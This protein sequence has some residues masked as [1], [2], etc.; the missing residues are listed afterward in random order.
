MVDSIPLVAD[1]DGTLYKGDITI[2][3]AFLLLKR[4]P[5]LFFKFL[6]LLLRG[7]APFKRA[8]ASNVEIEVEDLPWN[9]EFL[10]YLKAQAKLGRELLLVSASDELLVRPVGEHLGI[11][12]ESIGSDGEVNLK[13]QTKREYLVKRFGEKGFD[14]AGNDKADY[15]VW[16]SAKNAIVVNAR[17][18]VESKAKKSVNVSH[19]FPPE[20]EKWRSILKS[21]RVHQ[22]LKNLL[23][24]LPLVLAH[25]TSDLVLI[26]QAFLAFLAFCLCASA[27]YTINDAV[28]LEADRAHKNKRRRPLPAGDISLVDAISLAFVLLF[29][30]AILCTALPFLFTEC[31]ILYLAVCLLYSFVLKRIEI[32]D[33][34]VLAQLY[35]LRIMAGGVAVGVKVSHWLLG[36]SLFIFLSLAAVKRYSELR[37]IKNKQ[38]DKIHG[39]GYRPSD[40][41]Q[42]GVLGA[43]A[44]YI[45]VVV[46]A[47]YISSSEVTILYSHPQWLWLLCPLVLYWISR[48]WLLAHREQMNEDPI[49]FAAYDKV[50]YVVL[51]LCMLILGLAV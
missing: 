20:R 34:L 43:A 48:V 47:M 16:E 49:L 5:R 40:L 4:N 12:K 22:W 24:F 27:I 37:Q 38:L 46:L 25:R 11:F 8:I 33:V 29:S 14:Y 10:D 32:V 39:R 44:G 19:I 6:P 42:I 26:F 41:E 18:T 9:K 17:K 15:K 3:S 1:L 28:D 7:K 31:L 2:E 35:M 50:S 23:L 13:S 30:A 21:L 45:S 36:F 51:L